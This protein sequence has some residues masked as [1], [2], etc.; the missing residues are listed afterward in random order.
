[1]IHLIKTKSRHR[2]YVDFGNLGDEQIAAVLK[3][4]HARTSAMMPSVEFPEGSKRTVEDWTALVTL[5]DFM[6]KDLTMAR[7]DAMK[8][9][10]PKI[11]NTLEGEAQERIEALE[12][13][14][15]ELEDAEP[16]EPEDDDEG[17]EGP[18]YDANAAAVKRQQERIKRHQKR[19]EAFQGFREA[20]G[21]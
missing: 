20:L 17:D 6:S 7:I 21:V 11:L 2:H 16:E 12:D 4:A 18:S 10:G 3:V 13:E 8:A 14:L 9:A 1:M 19:L 15:A 5:R